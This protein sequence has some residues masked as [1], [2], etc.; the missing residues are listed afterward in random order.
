MLISVGLLQAP[1]REAL[2]PGPSPLAGRGETALAPASSPTATT[3]HHQKPETTNQKSRE[4]V[5]STPTATAT[6][7]RLPTGTATPTPV[8]TASLR[9]TPTQAQSTPFPPLAPTATGVWI[10]ATPL[11]GPA[12]VTRSTPITGTAPPPTDLVQILPP[13]SDRPDAALQMLLERLLADEPGDYSV[14]VKHLVSG[15]TAAVRPEVARESASVFKLLVMLE[16]FHQAASGTLRFDEPLTMTWQLSTTMQEY[17]LPE[18][19]VPVSQSVPLAEALDEMV[20]AS[21]NTKALLLLERVR[22]YRVNTTLAG[23]GI[24]RT[25]ILSGTWMTAG[26]AAH[27]LE[28][29]ATGQTVDETSARRML[30]LLLRQQVRDRIPAALPPGT[31]VANKTGNWDGVRNDVGIVYAPQGPFV[32]AVLSERLADGQA[33]TAFIARLARAVYDFFE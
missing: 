29:I 21:E 15:Q 9:T 27:I 14:A 18:P 4:G 12:P 5:G 13:V 33:G 8:R 31:L 30:T 6:P 3:T 22:A 16:T 7:Q 17:D 10:T 23:M 32:I 11:R 1:G 26:D 25:R 2:T 24:T 28:R 19:S 20:T